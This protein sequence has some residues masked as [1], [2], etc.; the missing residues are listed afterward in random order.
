[1]GRA[2]PPSGG[3]TSLRQPPSETYGYWQLPRL[4]QNKTREATPPC[5]PVGAGLQQAAFGRDVCPASAERRD[6]CLRC[7]APEVTRDRGLLF[8]SARFGLLTNCLMMINMARWLAEQFG[9]TP[10]LPLC[11]SSENPE[12]TCALRSER[13][14]PVQRLR[15]VMVN[16]SA[17][18]TTE[19]LGRCTSTHSHLER[20]HAVA[21]R[22]VARKH[23]RGA[24][25]L[26]CVGRRVEDCADDV[27]KDPQFDGAVL[28]RFVRS[29]AL[30]YALG[31]LNSRTDNSPPWNSSWTA[32]GAVSNQHEACCKPWVGA[33]SG[34]KTCLRIQC[35]RQCGSAA[36]PALQLKGDILVTGLFE[37][38]THRLRRPF[39]MCDP[40]QLQP[41]ARA[42][43]T[44]IVD[45]MG[46]M[47]FVCVHWRAG[48]FL[49]KTKISLNVHL[50]NARVMAAIT[51]SAARAVGASQALV[52]TNARVERQ[53]EMRAAAL[54]LGLKVQL[55]ACSA[56]PPDVEKHACAER[57]RALVLSA[58][59]TF[60]D[61]M[62]TLAPPGTPYA[63][64]GRCARPDMT[65][66][67]CLARPR[68]T[69][70]S[71]ASIATH[72][73]RVGRTFGECKM[74]LRPP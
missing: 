22:D 20:R 33:C 29:E 25:Q 51:A 46:G 57:G 26:T 18:Y 61:H 58:Y 74:W 71:T 68:M 54:A 13:L 42:E 11:S 17:I 53:A 34:P 16:M 39:S 30:E 41:W 56:V 70:A 43:A 23:R 38:A 6:E 19:S 66:A 52:L 65:V 44:Q 9:K 15:Y 72:S 62:L 4:P 10:V 60:S 21:L 7:S 63:F 3:G 2:Q 55:R 35:S 64:V 73:C 49:A 50:S 32:L 27:A 59:S 24:T 36:R 40:P 5:S 45:T 48:D 28:R 37:L 69:S 31:W 67:A 12:Q 14:F 1:M 8:F 47:P